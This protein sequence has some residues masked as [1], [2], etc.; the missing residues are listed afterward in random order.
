MDLN[1]RLLAFLEHE[2]KQIVEDRKRDPEDRS[3]ASAVLER[4]EGEIEWEEEQQLQP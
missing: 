1:P 2:M 3:H 4:I